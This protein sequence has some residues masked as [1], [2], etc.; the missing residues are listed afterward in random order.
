VFGGAVT[1]KNDALIKKIAQLEAAKP[2]PPRWWVAQ[3]LRHPIL[4]ALVKPL[5]FRGQLGKAILVFAQKMRLISFAVAPEEKLGQA[6]EHIAW[7]FSPALGVLLNQQ[8][9][10]LDRYTKARQETTQAYLAALP[11]RFTIPIGA[12]LLRFPY[13]TARPSA[14]FLEGQRQ[15]ILLGDWYVLPVVPVK[16]L[17]L[18]HY[19]SGSCPQAETVSHQMINLPTYPGLTHEQRDRVTA[20]A[21]TSAV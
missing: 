2:L 4:M 18:V 19:V 17:T 5:Y 10:K 6:P 3:Q 1:S 8:L 12:A 7:R 11:R 15:H 14:F 9:K 16:D 21:T 13:V 20:L